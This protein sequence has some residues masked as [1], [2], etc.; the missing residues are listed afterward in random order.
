MVPYGVKIMWMVLCTTGIPCTW[1]VLVAFA[2]TID[3]W[4]AAMTYCIATTIL[5]LTF[6]LGKFELDKL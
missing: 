3:S 4:W 1:V 6:D 2:K 5:V